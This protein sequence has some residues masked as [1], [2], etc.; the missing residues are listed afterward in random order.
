MSFGPS[1]PVFFDWKLFQ[2]AITG[3]DPH[4]PAQVKAHLLCPCLGQHSTSM[5]QNCSAAQT[6]IGQVE[7]TMGCTSRLLC[8][9]K[10]RHKWRQSDGEKN[11]PSTG[12]SQ[13]K[14]QWRH[15][16]SRMVHLVWRS[17]AFP[18][19]YKQLQGVKLLPKVIPR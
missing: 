8:C 4:I 5:L 9:S 2:A 17:P 7:M 19:V 13:G 12:N 15:S 14:E 3:S 11:S 16:G 1:L 6:N 18:T 10:P